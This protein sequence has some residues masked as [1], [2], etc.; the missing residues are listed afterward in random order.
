MWFEGYF[1]WSPPNLGGDAKFFVWLNR[2]ALP[3]KLFT[4]A[5]FMLLKKKKK[6]AEIPQI[7]FS[8]RIDSGKKKKEKQIKKKL[9]QN[10]TS[11]VNIRD[12]TEAKE[13][14]LIFF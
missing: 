9:F 5:L 3:F 2:Q 4:K 13:L 7:T 12:F 14:I 8:R 11:R 6:K 10:H 1:G